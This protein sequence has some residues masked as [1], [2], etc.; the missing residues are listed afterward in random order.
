MALPLLVAVG[1]TGDSDAG[2][3]GRVQVVASFYPLAFVAEEVGGNL[4]AVVNLTPPG[5]EPHD[6]ELTASQVRALADADLIVYI[7]G[8]FQPSVEDAISEL[9]AKAV[10]V[11]AGQ[12]DLLEPADSDEETEFDPHVW[13][14]PQRTA[15][16]A[17]LVSDRLA[18][19]DPNNED[20]YRS[21]ADALESRLRA[22]DDEFEEGVA[23][24]ESRSIVTSHEAFGYLAA[25]YDLE[26]IGIAGIDPEAEPSPRRLADVAEF[27]EDNDVTT[28]FFEELV[29]ADVAETLAEEAGVK[30]A[31]LDP[32]EG[33]PKSGDYLSAMRSNLTTLRQGLECT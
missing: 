28:I 30:T 17:R 9:G 11:L 8:G 12:E 31:R 16:I 14:D 32:L 3:S 1:C 18:E 4:V 27:V 13:L 6:L 21:N 22:L 19:V 33:P 15:A 2:E 10:D 24:C 26:E 23:D 29:P 25:T 5:A 20:A 7:G